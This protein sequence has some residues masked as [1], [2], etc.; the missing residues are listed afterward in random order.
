MR[1]PP[2]MIKGLLE[3]NP[4]KSTLLVGGLGV[5]QSRER[6]VVRG[7]ASGDLFGSFNIYIYIYIYICISFSLYIYIYIIMV[8]YIIS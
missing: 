3:S 7:R 6:A 1:I 2:L 5:L 4:L 8:E